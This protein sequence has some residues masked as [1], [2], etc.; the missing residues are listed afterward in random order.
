[1]KDFLVIIDISK[2]QDSTIAGEKG[3]DITTDLRQELQSA[4]KVLES[5]SESIFI[6]LKI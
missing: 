1:M 3:A 5:G 6:Y 2:F 4:R